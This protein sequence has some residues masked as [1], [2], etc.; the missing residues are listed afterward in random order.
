[1][2]VSVVMIVSLAGKLRG[3][4]GQPALS[5]RLDVFT[6]RAVLGLEHLNACGTQPGQRTGAD[7]AHQHRIH[8]LARQSLERMALAMCVVFVVIA[9][10]LGFG[11]RQIVQNEAG[12]RAEV[13]VREAVQAFVFHGGNADSHNMLAGQCPD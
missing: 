13:H 3:E 8:R 7:P 10:D 9:D 12:R 2:G 4:R 5:K 6:D 1:M 11:A